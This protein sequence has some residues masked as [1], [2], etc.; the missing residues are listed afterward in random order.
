YQPSAQAAARC[1]AAASAARLPARQLPEYRQDLLEQRRRGRAIC[2]RDDSPP[3]RR[4]HR[5]QRLTSAASRR[6]KTRPPIAWVGI[7][8]LSNVERNRARSALNLIRKTFVAR[9]DARNQRAKF[10]DQLD[11][12]ISDDECHWFLLFALRTNAG[13]TS[14]TTGARRRGPG[15]ERSSAR[16]GAAGAQR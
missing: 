3:H 6:V 9:L 15:C 10:L 8:A 12:Q 7:G 13:V 5:R 1:C 11:A 14:P 4:A 16:T 2:S